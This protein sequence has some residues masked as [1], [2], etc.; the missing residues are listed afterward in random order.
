MQAQALPLADASVD[1]AH[2]GGAIEHLEPVV[3]EAF[4][5][6]CHRVLRPGGVASHIF[7]HRDHLHHADRSW[8][9]LAHLGLRESAYRALRAHP[10]GYHS[11]LSPTRVAAI[12]EAAGFE[13]IALRRLVIPARCYVDDAVALQAEPG[14]PRWLLAVRFRDMSD[15][16]LRTAACHFL[17]RRR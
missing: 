13:A 10:L 16:D 14:L 7:D 5:A 11:R 2:S 9:F 12:F 4:A 15:L 3:L 6:E 8:P 17:Y 1:L